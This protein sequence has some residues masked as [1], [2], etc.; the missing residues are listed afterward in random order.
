MQSLFF[1]IEVN[2]QDFNVCLLLCMGNVLQ[3]PCNQRLHTFAKPPALLTFLLAWAILQDIC[4]IQDSYKDDYHHCFSIWSSLSPVVMRSHV[5]DSTS[6]NLTAITI[7]NNVVDCV[8]EL[9][10][11]LFSS[12]LQRTLLAMIW[13]RQGHL[14]NIDPWLL[15]I[16]SMHLWPASACLMNKKAFERFLER[17]HNK[18][19]YSGLFIE[20]GI[21]QMN[22]HPVLSKINYLDW[23]N[24]IFGIKDNLPAA[25]PSPAISRQHHLQHQVHWH[26]HLYWQRLWLLM[27]F[28]PC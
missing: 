2:N 17:M 8:Q 23:S 13:P 3:N 26:Q 28:P 16:R 24:H 1:S 27:L 14:G 7:P 12:L 15:F 18:A 19:V 6:R 10:C 21:Q 25:A 4:I 22:L 5:F 20:I 9:L 11:P